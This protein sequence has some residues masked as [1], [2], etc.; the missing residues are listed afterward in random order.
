MAKSFPELG[1]T[2][3]LLGRDPEKVR[4]SA[5]VIRGQVPGSVVIDEICD[6]GDLDAV[7]AMTDATR[8]WVGLRA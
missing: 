3:H 2:V 6:V 4:H 8:N 1:A 7:S 5:G